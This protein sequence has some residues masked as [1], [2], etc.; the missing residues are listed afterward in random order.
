MKMDVQTR[1][2]LILRGQYLTAAALPLQVCRGLNGLQAQY[3][4]NALHGLAIRSGAA[5]TTGLV[6][7]WTLRGTMHLFAVQDLPVF[8]YEGR[9]HFLRP[10]DK[11]EADACITL[12]RKQHFADLILAQLARGE[13]E[14]EQLKAACAAAGMTETEEKSL[15]DPWG[16]ILRH[17]AESGKIVCAPAQKKRYRLCP[18][19]TPMARP[20]A[21]QEQLRRYLTHYGPVTLRDAAYY[22]G[23]PKSELRPLMEA[24][25]PQQAETEGETCYWL[26]TDGALPEIPPCI[27]LAGFD[28]LLLGYEKKDGLFLPPA[29]LRRIFSLAG[30]VAPAVLL[31]GTGAGR[32]KQQRGRVEVELFRPVTQAERAAISAAAE[33]TFPAIKALNISE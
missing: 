26:P 31:G 9:T 8:L 5:D 19:F 1:K 24:L 33:Q 17:L 3:L 7:S 21:L 20:Q 27:F 10:Q 32:W 6:K 23:L 25:A 2:Q 15:F 28:P 30:G 11:M 16:G 4:S 22:F 29:H 12:A 13:A 14:R 18:A